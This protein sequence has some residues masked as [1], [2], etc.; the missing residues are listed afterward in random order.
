[1]PDEF[2]DTG[3]SIQRPEFLLGN[4]ERIQERQRAH[5]EGKWVREAASAY[6]EKQR[7]RADAA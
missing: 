3:N 4:R 2:H 5:D 7:T 6:A 1:M